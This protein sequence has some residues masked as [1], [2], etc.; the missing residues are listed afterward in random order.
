MSLCLCKVPTIADCN[1]SWWHNLELI[2]GNTLPM[3]EPEIN[4]TEIT[5]TAT[6]TGMSAYSTIPGIFPKRQLT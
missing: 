3:I 4:K 2:F 6:N 1:Q 5:T